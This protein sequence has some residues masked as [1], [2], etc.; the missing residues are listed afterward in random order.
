MRWGLIG[1][2][3]ASSAL[4]DN[5]SPWTTNCGTW[6]ATNQKGQTIGPAPSI[7]PDTTQG[8][9]GN[10]SINLNL[11]GCTG[12]PGP[13]GP[14]GPSGPAGPP[15]TAGSPGSVSILN[16]NP[17]SLIAFDAALSHPAWLEKGENFS[18]TGGFG[19]SQY[20]DTALGLTGIMRL[21][22]HA[23]GF[24]SMAVGPSDRLWG[25]RAGLRLGW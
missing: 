14:P 11:N 17:G 12:V 8:F 2:L 3:L 20:G 4:A 25:G 16:F 7:S 22:P 10:Y 24:G 1:V 9:G 13:P 6:S 23:A 19:F 21:G 5:I 15:G 18:L